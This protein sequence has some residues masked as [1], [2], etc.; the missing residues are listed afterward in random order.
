MHVWIDLRDR[1]GTILGTKGSQMDAKTTLMDLEG[2]PEAAKRSPKGSQIDP[3][4]LHI[5]S[6]FAFIGPKAS[7]GTSWCQKGTKKLQMG[8]AN[9]VPT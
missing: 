8:D 4:A 5:P 9:K 1:F 2:S 3:W 7:Q 6:I